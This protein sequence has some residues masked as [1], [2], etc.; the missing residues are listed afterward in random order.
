MTSYNFTFW[1]DERERQ[2][3]EEALELYVKHWEEREAAGEHC[4]YYKGAY[5]D[6][7]KRI[8]EKMFAGMEQVSGNNFDEGGNTIWIKE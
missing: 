6:T 3:I 4:A 5:K 7:A 2:A 1:V 8:N